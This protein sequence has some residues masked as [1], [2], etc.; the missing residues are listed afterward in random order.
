L[1]SGL[2]EH[3]P[4]AALLL[5]ARSKEPHQHA[6]LLILSAIKQGEN[7]NLGHFCADLKPV[8]RLTKGEMPQA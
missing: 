7:S 5:A 1:T 3:Q 2:L 8:D 4:Q 6:T